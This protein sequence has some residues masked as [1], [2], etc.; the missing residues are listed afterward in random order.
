MK[1]W[2]LGSVLFGLLA[3]LIVLFLIRGHV[4]LAPLVAVSLW[5]TMLVMAHH[6]FGM[7]G[8]LLFGF[9]VLLNAALYGA[10]GYATGLIS[11]RRKR[12]KQ[13]YP[14]DNS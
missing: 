7:T 13:A 1:R 5:P 6:I 3:P 12:V 14:G 9:S 4:K 2:F 10:M 8:R 11:Q